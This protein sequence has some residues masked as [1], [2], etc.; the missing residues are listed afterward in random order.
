MGLQIDTT[1]GIRGPLAR[2][3]LVEAIRD[4]PPDVQETDWLEWKSEV[5]LSA[6]HWHGE[7]ARQILG[8]ANRPP[9]RA[10]R[11]AAGHAYVVCG[12]EPGAIKGVA[13][14]DPA[15]LESVI[16]RY[17]GRGNG[18]VWEPHY[19]S[20]DGVS[21]LVVEI[22][23]PQRGDPAWPLRREYQ[24][25]GGRS[26]PAGRIFIRR[27]GK[28]VEASDAEIDQLWR[29][30]QAPTKELDIEL[31][32]WAEPVA[33]PPI[34]VTGEAVERFV[35]AEE[36]RLLAP[37]PAPLPRGMPELAAA[38]LLAGMGVLENRTVPEYRKEVADYIERLREAVP[39]AAEAAAVEH[40]TARVQFALENHTDH[41]FADLLVELHFPGPVRA[42]FEVDD[43]DGATDLPGPPW[44]WGDTRRF[45]AALH[46]AGLPSMDIK[47]RL[48]RFG[49]VDNT[50]ST[51]IR[52]PPVDMRPGYRHALDEVNLLVDPQLAGQTLTGRWTATSRSVSGISDDEFRV[53]IAAEPVDGVALLEN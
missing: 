50:G 8:M 25:A 3:A 21:A 27:Q 51:T 37:L 9:D 39:A 43:L 49:S 34:S 17:T 7:L 2:R 4:A 52:F 28:T 42:A 20:V 1:N 40:G 53:N 36:R 13:V 14:L 41:N 46:Y 29:R 6:K 15:D 11:S 10:A 44:L 16:G 45:T 38:G 31:A 32:W 24:D 26:V 23:A 30:A 5:D 12:A 48:P 18:P 35:L 47:P 19:V 22:A 33:V